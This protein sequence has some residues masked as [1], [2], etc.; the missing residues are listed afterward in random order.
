MNRAPTLSEQGVRLGQKCRFF[1][2]GLSPENFVSVQKAAEAGDSIAVAN[3][4]I[5]IS[6]DGVF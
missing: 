3:G 1:C 5:E 6:L 2:C 4:V